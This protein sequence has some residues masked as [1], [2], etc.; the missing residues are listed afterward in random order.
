M[1]RAEAKYRK[2]NKK[3][4]D[5]AVSERN[6]MFKQHHKL[7]SERDDLK[8]E[9][10]RKKRLAQQAMAARGEIKHFLD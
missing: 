4:K 1:F 3:E 9:L 6:D 10:E 2:E 7:V 5:L 8:S